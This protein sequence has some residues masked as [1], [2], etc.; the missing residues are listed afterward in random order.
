MSVSNIDEETALFVE[1]YSKYR[2]AYEGEH[3]TRDPAPYGHVRFPAR[4]PIHLSMFQGMANEFLRELANELNRLDSHIEQLRTWMRIYKDYDQ[5]D[6]MS[7][8]MEFI[9]PLASVTF[10]QPSALRSRYVYS[11]SHTSHQ[12]NLF[13]RQGWSESKLPAD[14]SINY[15][16]MK[17]CSSSWARF[18]EFSEAFDQLDNSPWKTKTREYRNRYHH[19][20]PPRFELGQTAYVTRSVGDNGSTSYGF[21]GGEPLSIEALLPH[22]R[23][24]HQHARTCFDMYSN[25]LMDQWAAI[26]VS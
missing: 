3:R 18:S 22:L 25:L 17:S 2:K 8:M 10:G 4:I 1:A 6:Q 20:F 14:G 11:L 26:N 5:E 15:K 7:I 24:Q 9:E 19:R 13:S 12:A 16:V 23:E 21:G